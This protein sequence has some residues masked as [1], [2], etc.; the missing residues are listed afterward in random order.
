MPIKRSNID[1]FAAHV[2]YFLFRGEIYM[3]KKG[4]IYVCHTFY[5]VF[6]SFLKELNLPKE[7]QGQATLV[8][9]SISNDFENLADRVRAGKTFVNAY[10]FDEKKGRIFPGV[11]EI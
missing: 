8:L 10:E 6:V 9:S 7:E 3:E 5:H 4:N 1:T 11:D 2:L